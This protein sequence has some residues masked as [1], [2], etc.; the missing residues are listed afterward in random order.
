M[1][2]LFKK[3]LGL[4]WLLVLA[5]YA[6]LAIGV[7]AIHSA[8]WMKDEPVIHNAHERQLLFIAIGTIVFF[9]TSLVDYR[10]VSWGGT[11]LYLTGVALSAY[12]LLMGDDV[13]GH[14]SWV[15]IV[16][17]TFQP[18]QLAIAGGIIVT[19]LILGEMGRFHPFLRNP[20]FKLALVGLA[21][22]IPF[23]V[24]ILQGDF[25]SAMVWLPVSAAL[26]LVGN[27]PFRYMV[28]V[29]LL[30]FM[31]IPWAYYFGL[32]PHQKERITVYADML[33]GKAVDTQ[34]SAY[35][36]S[37]IEKA[38]GSG[39]FNGKGR[40][41][42]KTINNLG[43]IPKRTAINDFIFAVWAEEMGFRGSVVILGGFTIILLQGLF[44]A[45][46]ARDAVG[47]LICVGVVALIFAHVF[48]HVGMN[49]LIMPITGIPL[50]FLSAGGTFVVVCMFLCGI[51]QS[52][53]VHRGTAAS[54][55]ALAGE[56]PLFGAS[57]P[58]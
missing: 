43:F 15:R 3:F 55:I 26:L 46:H 19:S 22:G 33:R 57:A 50:P 35:A 5:M 54:R 11:P 52:V 27:I 49:L 29:G 18:S 9:A 40:L 14:Q 20:F 1:T 36:A 2:P 25:G 32:K 39:G 13:Y 17:I 56:T 48:Q 24:V 21:C 31:V 16:G 23:A 58:A 7:V 42:E 4:N 28:T 8:G 37:Y 41:N 44:I 51:M 12:A 6:L 47:R 30:G 34:G 10:W 45:F 38:V 53:W